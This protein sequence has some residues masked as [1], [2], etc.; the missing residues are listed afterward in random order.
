MG[1]P[2]SAALATTL[3]QLVARLRLF[4]LKMDRVKVSQIRILVKGFFDVAQENGAKIQPP[5]HI[6]A[7]PP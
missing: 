6:K 2:F 4:S 3:R 1:I 5:R 7:M